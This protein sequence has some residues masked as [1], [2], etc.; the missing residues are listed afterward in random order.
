MMC[1]K[2]IYTYLGASQFALFNLA[3]SLGQ[4]D[5]E[6]PFNTYQNATKSQKNLTRARQI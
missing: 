5:V 6:L 1:V 2:K 3:R 4:T